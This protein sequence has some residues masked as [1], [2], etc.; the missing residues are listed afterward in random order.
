MRLQCKDGA[1]LRVVRCACELHKF[2]ENVYLVLN[3]ICNCLLGN[4]TT[5]SPT[6]RGGG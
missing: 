3:A 1:V 4:T 2:V 6:Q 5:I